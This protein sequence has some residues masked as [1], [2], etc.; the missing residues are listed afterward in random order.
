VVALAAAAAFAATGAAR[1]IGDPPIVHVS[2]PRYTGYH[3][4]SSAMEPTLHCARPGYGCLGTYPDRLVVQPLRTGPERGDILVFDTPPLAQI[5]CGAGGTFVKRVIAL[6]GEVFSERRGYVYVNGK[7]LDEPYV[8]ASR[9][10]SQTVPPRKL[11][12]G[13]Y[14]LMGDNRPYSCDSREWGP[15]PRKNIVGKVVKVFRQP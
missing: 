15:V 10:D 9:R 1:T 14:F 4:P 7:K 2:A 3:M 6:P 8:Q 5:R 12:A 13:A 11:P